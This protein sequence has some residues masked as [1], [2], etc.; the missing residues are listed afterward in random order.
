[1]TALSI[2]QIRQALQHM[3]RYA[4]GE[5]TRP[6]MQIPANPQED[7][8]LI[9]SAAID[10]LEQL[11]GDG[12]LPDVAA[13]RKRQDAKWGQQNHPDLSSLLKGLRPES[14][15]GVMGVPTAAHAKAT[16]DRRAR[17]GR[18]GYADIALEEFCESIEQA[19]LG[20]DQALR[21]E[22]VQTA[23]VLVAWI[24]CIDRRVAKRGSE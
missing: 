24:E 4:T 22:L 15:F 16:C 11:R 8:D 1:M 12:V 7:A 13:E 14:V 23:A 18:L 10:E 20:D 19:A 6:Y 21:N 3:H 17:V 9:L 5:T 2:E